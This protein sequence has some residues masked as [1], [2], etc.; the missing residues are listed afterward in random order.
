[1]YIHTPFV[2]QRPRTKTSPAQPNPVQST[3]AP[4]RRD[5]LTLAKTSS[6]NVIPDPQGASPAD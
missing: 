6:N 5:Y 1:M 4:P 3:S 2:L